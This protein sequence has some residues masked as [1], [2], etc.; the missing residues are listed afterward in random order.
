MKDLVDKCLSN[1]TLAILTLILAMIS[2]LMTN[3]A[4]RMF[5]MFNEEINLSIHSHNRTIIINNHNTATMTREEIQMYGIHPHLQSSNK[6]ST[7]EDHLEEC[8]WEWEDHQWETGAAIKTEVAWNHHLLNK[9]NRLWLVKAEEVEE[10][11]LG[12]RKI[13]RRT[14]D[15]TSHGW[16]DWTKEVRMG[17]QMDQ[18]RKTHFCTV[19]ILMGSVLILN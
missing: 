11:W 12:S 16:M 18:T 14:G 4:L 9:G 10:L 15:M 17:K 3:S 7:V 2:P 8:L 1:I 13:S 19:C 6:G 5:T